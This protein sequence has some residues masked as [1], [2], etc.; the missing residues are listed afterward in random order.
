M[1]LGEAHYGDSR[2]GR[3]GVDSSS[4]HAPTGGRR[5]EARHHHTNA[6]AGSKGEGFGLRIAWPIQSGLETPSGSLS[7]HDHFVPSVPIPES[8]ADGFETPVSKTVPSV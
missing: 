2:E 3:P 5:G 8:N 4:D 7:G 6:T 1:P